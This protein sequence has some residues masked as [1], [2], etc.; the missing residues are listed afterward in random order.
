MKN[1]QAFHLYEEIRKNN[2]NPQQFLNDIT[3]KYTP[4]QMKQFEQFVGQFGITTEQLN[5]LGINTQ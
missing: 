5:G 1:P 4:E 2:N 3:N